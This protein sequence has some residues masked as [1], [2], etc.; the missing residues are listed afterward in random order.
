MISVYDK[1][2]ARALLFDAETD[3]RGREAEKRA[4]PKRSMRRP[5]GSALERQK[6]I[7]KQRKAKRYSDYLEAQEQR[8]KDSERNI[9]DALERKAQRR[10]RR[11]QDALDAIENPGAVGHVN[12]TS[13]MVEL[14]D[15]EEKRKQEH[16]YQDWKEGVFDRIQQNINDQVD[17]QPQTGEGSAAAKRRE[18]FQQYLDV[19][20]GKGPIFR[21]I[22]IES[23][24]VDGG[25]G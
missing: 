13:K 6:V 8:M 3:R 5:R 23:E 11:F 4:S 9:R 18:A 15:H 24:Y 12:R 17:A 16:F 21:D 7:E 1:D 19:T 10:D 22:I 25:W 14:H 20:N 2:R